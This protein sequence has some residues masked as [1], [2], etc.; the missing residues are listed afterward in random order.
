M[1]KRYA[2]YTAED[3]LYELEKERGLTE[4]HFQMA[5]GSMLAVSYP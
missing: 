5:D 4:K 1:D 2:E 3:V